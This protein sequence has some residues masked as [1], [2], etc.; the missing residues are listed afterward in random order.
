MRARTTSNDPSARSWGRR[1][2]LASAVF[3]G[4]A[5]LGLG[6]SAHAAGDVSAEE[7]A[8]QALATKAGLGPFRTSELEPY[9]GIGDAPD[10]Y[11]INALKRCRALAKAYE[12][13][14][15]DK[16]LAV[17]FPSTRLTVVTLKDKESYASFL[18][19]EPGGAVG[20]HYDLDTSRLVIFDF[21]PGGDPKA[22]A[23]LEQI[24]SF[25]LIHEATHQLTFNT[26]L[27]DRLG[28]VPKI[29]SEG[30]AMY[31]ELWR[32]EGRSLPAV[33]LGTVN[34]PRLQVLINQAKE[35]EAWIDLGTL[36]TDDT[37]FER[38]ETEQLAYAEAWVL[39]HH[40]LKTPAMLPKFRAYLDA[41]RPRRAA[42]DRL[43]DARAHLGAL[44]PLNLALRKHASRMIRG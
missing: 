26:G 14:F 9:L 22:R 7:G 35:A 29:I 31:A 21:R 43:A 20:G 3:L 10:A 12:K 17:T 40:L 34:R 18:G 1:E 6:T 19:E 32:P 8:I 27:L 41:I 4:G 5:G 24:N 28:D 11:R 37:F 2:W 15:R 23:G 42:S 44:E 36:L 33:G 39:V 13:H 38:A 25:T 16:G 30:L